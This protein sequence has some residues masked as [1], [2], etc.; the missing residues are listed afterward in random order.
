MIE[1]K[2]PLGLKEH[3]TGSPFRVLV[4]D[5][6]IFIAKQL[7]QILTSEK[8]E[9]AGTMV[10]GEQAVESYK[11]M[12]PDIDLV[13]LDI[14][15]P[16]MDGVTA[17]E[18]IIAFDPQAKVIMVSALG[19]EDVVKKCLQMG[20]KSYILKPLNREKVLERIKA[21]LDI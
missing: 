5:D 21:V 13:T 3:G 8:F 9:V 12:S 16:V 7:G 2:I 10:N 20:A 15:M 6:S 1:E 18:K 17:L 4:T 11:E 14:T 19:K